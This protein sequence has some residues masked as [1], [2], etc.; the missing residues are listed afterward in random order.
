MDGAKCKFVKLSNDLTSA[1][2]IKEKLQ[3]DFNK[4]C[5]VENFFVAFMLVF[6]LVVI[7]SLSKKK[8]GHYRPGSLLY[9]LS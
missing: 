1:R 9:R 6:I 2:S 4:Q 8:P 3:P 7:G 5:F